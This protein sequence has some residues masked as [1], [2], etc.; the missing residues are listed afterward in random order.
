MC[1]TQPADKGKMKRGGRQ[2][3][4]ESDG[5]G[6]ASGQKYSPRAMGATRGIFLF[7]SWAI[8][9][10]GQKDP[11]RAGA[12]QEEQGDPLE[13]VMLAKLHSIGNASEQGGAW[14]QRAGG[15][16]ALIYPVTPPQQR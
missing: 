11:E 8:T 16:R 3:T 5:G 15:G 14:W 9:Y 13:S 6:E 7:P 4:A 2:T 1:S 12:G 10:L